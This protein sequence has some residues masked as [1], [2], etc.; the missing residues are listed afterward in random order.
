ME[1]LVLDTS[2]L[3]VARVAWQRAITLIFAGKAEVVEEY[4]DKEIRSVT[5]AIKMP[6][7]IRFLRALRGRKKAIKFSRENVYTRDHGQCQY[8]GGK[9]ARPQATYDHVLP[10]SQGGKT[11]WENV[12]ISCYDCNQ[13]KA[14]RTPEQ[15]R[16]KLRSLPVRPKKLP[17]TFHLTFAWKPGM[18]GA[19]Q[20]WL[21]NAIRDMVY[22]NGELD[23]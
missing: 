8:C 15:A 22:W 9:V 11:T 19:W 14:G 21:R 13:K 3:P 7:V 1:T 10:R 20:A 23:P 6:S 18:P 4:E 5:F 2:Y 12:V 16:M 17:D